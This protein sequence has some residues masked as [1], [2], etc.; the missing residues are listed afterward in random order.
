MTVLRTLLILLVIACSHVGAQAQEPILR[1]V[2]SEW[3]PYVDASVTRKGV[4]P[5]LVRAALRRAGYRVQLYIDY[6]PR[7]LEATQSG[8]FDAIVSLWFT[9][10]RAETIAFSEPFMTNRLLFMKRSA[11]DIQLTERED[12]VGL[13]VG[14]VEDYAY[15]EQQYDTSGIEIVS[16]GSVGDNVDKLLAGE[17][18]L[19]LGDE[20]VLR[21]QADIRRASKQVEVLPL[22]L[23][24]RDL[25]FGVSRRRP[26]HEAIVAAFNKGI[27]A[28]KADG[29]YASLLANYRISN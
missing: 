9:D 15:S 2:A 11:D 8:D 20:L 25:H 7:S 5:Q 19:V 3:P 26:D 12:F 23:E 24:S 17:V 16:G 14:V 1:L 10:E 6:W 22:V 21:H 29:S 13:R 28:M 4:A 18:D 27:E